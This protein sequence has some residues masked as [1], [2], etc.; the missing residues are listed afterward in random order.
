VGSH[1]FQVLRA[2]TL[3]CSSVYTDE[4]EYEIRE[5]TF[6]VLASL[7]DDRR[8]GYGIIQEVE[9]LSNGG[10]RLR[11]GT[12]YAMLDRL[13][14]DGLIH[15]AGEEVVD[16]RLRRYYRLTAQGIA[17]LEAESRRRMAVSKEALRRL[18]VAGS[19]A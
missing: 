6:L 8:H 10:T 13:T 11:P 1:R 18:R 4:V 19:L 15:V 5:P 3:V 7:A 16:G 17:T 9:R 14:H 2:L 12:L